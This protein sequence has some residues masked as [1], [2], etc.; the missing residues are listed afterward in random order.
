[1]SGTNSKQ[2]SPRTKEVRQ[3]IRKAMMH[4]KS[5]STY[6]QNVKAIS[7]NGTVTLMAQ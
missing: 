7:Q 4:D 6:A 1:M 2:K 3:Q 5:L